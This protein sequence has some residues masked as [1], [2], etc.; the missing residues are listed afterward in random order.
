MTAI[1]YRNTSTTLPGWVKPLHVS[2]PQGIAYETSTHFIHY[3][4]SATDLYTISVGLTAS[5]R[6]NGLLND[7]VTRVFG[8]QDI[9]PSIH[10]PGETVRGVWRPGL[11]F[12]DETLQGLGNTETELRMAEQALRLLLDRLDELFLYIEPD[13]HGLQAYSHKTRELLILACTELENIWKEYM[14]ITG[15]AT[16]GSVCTTNDYVRLLAPLF[17][18]EYEIT[19]RSYSS[20]PPVQPFSTWSASA[21]TQS[22]PWY[23]AYNKTKHDR[24]THFDLATLAN[25][26][27]SVAA[28]IVLH[29]VRFSPFPL[30]EG[31]GTLSPLFN[32]AFSVR[33]HN[34]RA[35]TFYIPLI[36][37]AI[38][39]RDE[40][41]WGDRREDIAPR[42]VKPLVL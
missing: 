11:Y 40:L 10:V 3:Y 23:D 14:R 4:G 9:R 36:N 16:S 42:T 21:P 20:I 2:L 7:W 37:P 34:P 30:L 8:A 12:Y 41:V 5:E 6:K 25:C 22:L 28:N 1:V 17:L 31:R 27:A 15:V 18:D 39:L 26:I 33:L 38:S 13:T 24:S 29:C 19:L 35:E 32:Q